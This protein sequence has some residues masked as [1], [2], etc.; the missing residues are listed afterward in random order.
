MTHRVIS[1]VDEEYKEWLSS[2]KAD[3]KRSQIKAATKVNAELIA[4]NWRLGRS[5]ALLRAESKWGNGFF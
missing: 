5:I 3:Y 1:I 4:F 2:I